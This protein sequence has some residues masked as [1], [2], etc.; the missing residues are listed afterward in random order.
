MPAQPAPSS[1]R[2]EDPSVAVVIATRLRETRLAFALEALA[3]QTLDPDRFEVIVVRASDGADGALA[4]VPP[5]LR[6]RCITSPVAGAAAQRNLGWRAT[7]APLVAFTDDDCRPAPDW[8]ERLLDVGAGPATMLQGR[9]EP[10][11]DERHLL[12]GLARSWEI[13]AANGWYATCNMAY[14]RALLERLGGFDD[15]FPGA[16]GEDTDLGLRAHEVGAGL[17]YVDDA[18][19]WHAVVPRPLPRALREA[20][21]RGSTA[22]VVTRHPVHRAELYGR[23]FAHE[24]HAKLLL[25]AA[26]LIA[27]RRR[28][29]LAAATALPYLNAVYGRDTVT[30]RGLLRLAAH[31]PARVSIDMTELVIT[32]R[33]AIRHR[34]LL[35]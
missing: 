18:L 9:T 11:P 7:E 19:V 33:A 32:V 23:I 25:A 21:R 22:A 3:G 16:W 20:R 30:V 10:D 27:L 31:L 14:P 8:L 34:V 24:R 13:T 1:P 6:I 4:D 17:A 26:G 12:W 2:P 15:R 35:V 5:G 28:P 29:L